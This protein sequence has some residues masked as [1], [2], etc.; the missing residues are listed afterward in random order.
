[1]L[2]AFGKPPVGLGRPTVGADGWLWLTS[3]RGGKFDQ[4]SIL[5]VRPDGRD[6]ETVFAD[7]NWGA[8]TGV[9]PRGHLLL[10]EDGNLYGTTL[11]SGEGGGSFGGRG[12]LFKVAPDG[13][14]TTLVVF[15]GIEGAK[16]GDF[17]WGPLVQGRDGAIYGTT[18]LGGSANL[19][20]IFK[21]GN[22]E[23]TTLFE[24]SEP[25]EHGYDPTSLVEGP[26]GNFYG[27]AA[28]GANNS[29]VI[30]RMTPAGSV[31]P[32]LAFTGSAGA[33]PG[34]SV[35]E[36]S[37][38]R[39]GN[40]YGVTNAV[41]DPNLPEF[42]GSVFRLTTGGAFT[43]LAVFSGAAGPQRGRYPNGPLVED[44]DGVLYGSTSQGGNHGYGT[45]FKIT[46]AGVLTTLVDFT[47]APTALTRGVDGAFYG[48]F[49]PEY[50]SPA[51][52]SLFRLTGEGAVSSV[53]TFGGFS[54]DN[55]GKK[56]GGLILARDGSFYGTTIEGGEANGGT[57]FHFDP[58]R[59]FTSLAEFGSFFGALGSKPNA[60]PIQGSDGAFYGTTLFGG[61]SGNGTVY[62]A[63]AEG[64]LRTLKTFSGTSDGGFPR[65]PL[66]RGP[67]DAFYGTTASGAGTAF[68]ITATGE[69]TKLADFGSPGSLYAGDPV[70]GLALAH[71][72]AFYGGT[73]ALNGRSALF[74]LT[75]EGALTAFFWT[76]GLEMTG[77]LIQGRDFAL[78][79]TTS[80]GGSQS[81]GTVFRVSLDGQMT[82]LAS[83]DRQ[84]PY[85]Y[86]PLA[87]LVERSD[88]VLYGT[89]ADVGAYG[90]GSVFSIT[91]TGTYTKLLDFTGQGDQPFSGAR[92]L[93]SPL[94][95]GV[96]G[97]LYGTTSEGG[98]LGGGTIF[99]IALPPPVAIP[100]TRIVVASGAEGSG[101]AGE[102]EGTRYAQLRLPAVDP[103][104][105]LAF[106]AVLS[107]P[108]ETRVRCI[109]AGDPVRVLVREG[110]LAPGSGGAVFANFGDPVLSSEGVAFSAKLADGRVGVWTTAF[111][112]GVFELVAITGAAAPGLPEVIIRKFAGFSLRGGEIAML[113][114]LE[115]GAGGVTSGDDVA[116]ARFDRSGRDLLLRK[117]DLIAA[118][119]S[120]VPSPIQS[121][122]TFISGRR[123]PGQGGAHA[124]GAVAVRAR[125]L[126]GQTVL[127]LARSDRTT[128]MVAGSGGSVSLGERT[129]RW[130]SLGL[131]SAG[132]ITAH[133]YRGAL[134][135]DP[136]FIM[137]GVDKMIHFEE[138]QTDLNVSFREGDVAPG[139]NGLQ[140]GSL[141]DAAINDR[142]VGAFLASLSDPL[143]VSYGRSLWSNAGGGNFRRVAA[144]GEIARDKYG[145]LG[146]GA[147]LS[148]RRFTVPE[149]L[150]TVFFT[151]KVSSSAGTGVAFYGVDSSGAPRELL[152]VGDTLGFGGASRVVRRFQALGPGRHVLPNRRRFAS[153]SATTLLVDFVD[154][155]QG[156]VA[157]ELPPS[158]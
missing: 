124:E 131:F 141:R 4:G 133:A 154:G 90:F 87:G 13:T 3:E 80:W 57:F 67:D 26:D 88:G 18:S 93:Y 55:P 48:A 62:R 89:T 49:V 65:A 134:V 137:E 34:N 82:L 28:G 79:G 2:W 152:R 46:P 40:F 64:E 98:P 103:D 54:R 127:L 30:F 147:Y 111:Q 9:W 41:A 56:P 66:T 106:R 92:P 73:W 52:A 11:F 14:F 42:H 96:D 39:D 143:G 99:R 69:F 51:L 109:C 129:G 70:A 156:I 37:V 6:W 47:S 132:S 12:T 142:G 20:T 59:G 155:T 25:D 81:G 29:G 113:L 31:T 19:G 121:I 138:P 8:G 100:E 94:V 72:G 75:A 58:A 130:R 61:T 43:T 101:V 95:F 122:R 7:F 17:P 123:T 71:D 128:E 157:I 32:F 145:G 27:A 102:P 135:V 119:G 126:D 45:A 118:P 158:F 86:G 116:L 115:W 125:L 76:D 153:G 22:G 84:N 21:V 35:R 44:E 105:G 78:Y 24:F 149:G 85:H 38:G 53:A 50:N 104:N 97:N 136:P 16:R 107:M 140:F 63:T 117:G 148:I 74:R 36:F 77:A 15:S 120:A 150:H 60:A 33:A 151:A 68:R 91:P 110:D 23:F 139:S 146:S 108:D 112:E 5:K 114:K 144:R 83:F 1:V 10:A